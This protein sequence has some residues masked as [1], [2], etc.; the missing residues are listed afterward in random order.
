MSIIG[1][2]LV[3]F[4]SDWS[5]IAVMASFFIYLHRDNFKKQ[6]LDIVIWSAIYA[7]V[8]FI[9]LN[10]PYG[11]LQI[12]TFLSIPI[13]SMYSGQRGNW[14]GMKWFFYIYYPAH[15]IIIGIIRISLHGDISLIF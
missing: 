5:S 15:L 4:L 11:L 3:S 13:L 8:Y 7:A 10:K 2:C 14:K 12:F 9:F 6:A 1:I